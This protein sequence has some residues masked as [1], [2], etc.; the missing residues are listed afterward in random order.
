MQKALKLSK[1]KYL[2][3]TLSSF[4]PVK[5]EI[6]AKYWILLSN[7]RIK[8]YSSKFSCSI[9]LRKWL[10]I[11]ANYLNEI[12]GNYSTGTWRNLMAFFNVFN[13]NFLSL[14]FNWDS[15]HA[16]LKGIVKRAEPCKC[17]FF[18]FQGYP[19]IRESTLF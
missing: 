17:D 4:C 14:F 8:R 3:T 13:S 16:R 12:T 5:Q 11:I 19:D 10:A 9:N 15:R 1:W 18:L 2:K 6:I 7:F